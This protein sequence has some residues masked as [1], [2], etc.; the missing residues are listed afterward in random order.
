MA[1]GGH[2]EKLA[3]QKACGRDILWTVGWIAFKFNAV[4]LLVFLMIWFTFGK[5]P[6]KTRCREDILKKIASQKHC[7]RDILWT[8]G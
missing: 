2:F 8:V 7:G 3:A 5:N 4:V 6:L 1:D